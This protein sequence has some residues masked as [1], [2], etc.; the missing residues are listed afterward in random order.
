ML[1]VKYLHGITESVGEVQLS[2]FKA[3]HCGQRTEDS[4][5]Q[6]SWKHWKNIDDVKEMTLLC[7]DL[8]QEPGS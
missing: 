4:D 8:E 3:L 7:S 5:Q 1:M 2:V 6:Q